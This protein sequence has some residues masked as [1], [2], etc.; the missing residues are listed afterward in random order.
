[1]RHPT[2]FAHQAVTRF[3]VAGTGWRDRLTRRVAGD[4]VEMHVTDWAGT[5]FFVRATFRRTRTFGMV[6]MLP[7]EA[8]RTLIQVRI[9]VKRSASG[10]GR[11]L[12]DP[13]NARVRRYFIRKFLEPDVARS[14]GTRYDPH[15]LIEADRYL[16]DYFAW[17]RE[18]HGPA[19]MSP[20]PSEGSPS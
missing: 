10:V 16:A 6:S 8:D 2:P 15:R 17:L 3:R 19:A 12:W 20:T 14:A 4:E 13:L 7:V 9:S 1:V 11:L 5:L 18:L